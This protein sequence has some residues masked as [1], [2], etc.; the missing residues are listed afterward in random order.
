M[1]PNYY[2]Y[3]F[4]TGKLLEVKLVS[5]YIVDSWNHLRASAG[6]KK[7]ILNNQKLNIVSQYTGEVVTGY[8]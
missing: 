7:P 4:T 6:A 3:Y 8:F 5:E 2:Y 1:P